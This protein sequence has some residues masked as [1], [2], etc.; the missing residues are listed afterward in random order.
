MRESY[1]QDARLEPI[2]PEPLRDSSKEKPFLQY[3]HLA[4]NTSSLRSVFVSGEFG[5]QNKR[6]EANR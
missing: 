4:A 3:Q 1:A 2:M 5:E 6:I